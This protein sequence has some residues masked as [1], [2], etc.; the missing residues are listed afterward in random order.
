[1]TELRE[2]FNQWI[3]AK[4]GEA[5]AISSQTDDDRL[6]WAMVVAYCSAGKPI[7]MSAGQNEQRFQRMRAAF[8][9]L[10][11][12]HTAIEDRQAREA[13]EARVAK[14]R[15]AIEKA[16]HSPACACV[17]SVNDEGEPVHT[18]EHIYPCDCWKSLADSEG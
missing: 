11:T 8:G 17:M 7:P 10:I 16:P 15:E 18:A 1:M 14:L 6:I 13:A 9:V 4:I 2:D 5:G 3:S 12:H